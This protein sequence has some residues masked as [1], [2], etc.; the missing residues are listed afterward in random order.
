MYSRCLALNSRLCD[1]FQGVSAYLKNLYNESLPQRYKQ[2]QI[3][4]KVPTRDVEGYTQIRTVFV[5]L[6]LLSHNA[7]E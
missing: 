1:V 2:C 6:Y 5:L 3:T 7:K 4:P